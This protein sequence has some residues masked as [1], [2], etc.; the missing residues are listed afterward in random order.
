MATLTRKLIASQ[1]IAGLL[2]GLLLSVLLQHQISGLIIQ[3]FLDQGRVSARAIASGLGPKIE[4]RDARGIQTEL[5]DGVAAAEADWG[6]VTDSSGEVVAQTLEG[7][8]PE[9]LRKSQP[10]TAA[11]PEP[12]SIPGETARFYLV[13]EP[14]EGGNAGTVYLGF[15]EVRLQATQRRAALV[16]LVTVLAVVALGVG[17]L[18]LIARRHL[19]PV[20][21]LT[22]GAQ[23]FAEAGALAWEPI[24]VMSRDEVGLL[25]EAFNLMAEKVRGQQRD[26]EARVRERT[27]ELT[28]L[29]RRLEQDIQLRQLAQDALARNERMFRTLTAASPVGVFQA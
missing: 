25:T 6:Y 27:E 10:T 24:P 1:V 11:H 28:R 16:M 17:A 2:A 7:K 5:E 9:A 18:S 8:L 13:G 20:H 19:S 26:M 15:R 29:N 12:L 23:A 21:A 14:I 3:D 4:A 22:A